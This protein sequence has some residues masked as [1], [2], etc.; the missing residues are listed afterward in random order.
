MSKM[1]LMIFSS[2]EDWEWMR[3][4]SE[5]RSLRA[6]GAGQRFLRGLWPGGVPANQPDSVN[7]THLTLQTT[8]SLF[9]CIQVIF[10]NA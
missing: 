8:T 10:C 7:C 1:M 9:S 3:Y 4:L 6:S 5:N 2:I